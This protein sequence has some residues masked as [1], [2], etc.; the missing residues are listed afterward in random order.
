MKAILKTAPARGITVADIPEPVR[1]ADPVIKID[2]ASICGSDV[3]AYEWSAAYEGFLTMPRVL[4]HE[5]C[6][7]VV[8][9][10][11]SDLAVGQRVLVDP[12]IACG[13]C[14][15]CRTGRDN[16]CPDR[17]IIGW[18]RDGVF[19]EYTAVP[20]GNCIPLPDSIPDATA[21]CLESLGVAVRVMENAAPVIGDSVA[22][23][24]PGPLGLMS[25]LLCKMAGLAPVI[26]FGARQDEG[27]RMQLAEELGADLVLYAED[28]ESR[29][30]FLQASG[31]YGVDH[32][33]EWSGAAAGLVM[34]SSLAKP[35][36]AI[37]VGGIYGKPV[38][39]DVT[40]L[41]RREISL[42]T[43]RSRPYGTWRRTL[44]MVAGGTIDIAP[45]ISRTFSL[46]QAE[47]AFGL[48]AE[49]K[50]LKAVFRF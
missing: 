50:I 40:S 10:G 41:V 25:L 22:I 29:S 37:T 38:E 23:I 36:G 1:G 47:E 13:S 17:N 8:H 15:Y 11:E 49:K 12:G 3:H 6:G 28:P 20:A 42:L 33:F 46:D 44:N 21:A 18:R 7:R 45:L 35:G 31:G 4:G 19:A 39:L 32:V 14:L 43:A 26:V 27:L 9:P 5:G 30:L 16:I 48:A 34:A 24:G 2:A